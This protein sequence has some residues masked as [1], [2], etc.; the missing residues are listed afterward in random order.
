VATHA[1]QKQ[2]SKLEK[3]VEEMEKLIDYAHHFLSARLEA[4]NDIG[5]VLSMKQ[6]LKYE[7]HKEK[8]AK[9]VADLEEIMLEATL[10][11]TDVDYETMI[12]PILEEAERKPSSSTP[13]SCS[14]QSNRDI[15]EQARQRV[16][17]T[18]I[19]AYRQSKESPRAA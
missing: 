15:V 4:K 11:E 6:L 18:S 5:V 12:Q 17:A 7:A 8:Y 2:I 16:H 19:W 10:S 9:A 3:K 13:C 14:L 1:I